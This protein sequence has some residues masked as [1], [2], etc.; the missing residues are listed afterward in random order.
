MDEKHVFGIRFKNIQQDPKNTGSES[1]SGILKAQQQF[2][3][4]PEPLTNT[5]VPHTAD[6]VLLY[7]RKL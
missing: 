2:Q 4:Q 6:G 7:Q 5:P 3:K 1:G